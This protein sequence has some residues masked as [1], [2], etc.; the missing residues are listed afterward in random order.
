MIDDPL[1][2]YVRAK[3][4]CVFRNGTRILVE[5][6]YDPTKDEHFYVPPGGRIE[7]GESSEAA[8]HREMKE[9]L[10]TEIEAPRLLGVLE[11]LFTFDGRQAHEIIF[12]YD[13][14][15][16]NTS[17][18]DVPQFEAHES[19]GQV[20]S[21]VWIDID[22]MGPDARPIYPDGLLELLKKGKHED[23]KTT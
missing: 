13:A 17:L 18:Y 6:G 12:V 5:E 2:G 23:R 22:F 10:G 11:N 15:L 19:N 8:L 3:A 7:F 1:T 14:Q 16:V 9:E 21:A 4:I 20:L